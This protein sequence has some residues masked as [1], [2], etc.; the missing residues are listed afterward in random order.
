[1]LSGDLNERFLPWLSAL[2]LAKSQ[3]LPLWCDDVGVRTL[4]M[5]HGVATFGTSALLAALVETAVI[6]Q[7]TAQGALRQLRESY[8]VDLPFDAEWLRLSAGSDEW[9]PGPSAFH[10]SRAAAWADVKTAFPLWSELT[11]AAGNVEPIRVTGW[12]HSAA[13]GLAEA[14]DTT[15]AP[16]VLAGVAVQGIAHAKFDQEAIAACT[17]RVREVA[18]AHGIGS[19]VPHVIAILLKHLTE[20]I[21]AEA[22]ARHLLSDHL[23]DEDRSIVRDLILGIG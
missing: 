4:A 3:G 2:D 16:Y 1:M 14:V 18:L 22:A 10:F 9:R 5:N 8:A 15:K 17:A 6:G 12:V 13:V 23:A 19:P 7:G 21:G 20:A 11:Q